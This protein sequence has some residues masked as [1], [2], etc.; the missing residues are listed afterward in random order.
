M[1]I[2]FY[3]L[4]S[5]RYAPMDKPQDERA[6]SVKLAPNATSYRINGLIRSKPYMIHLYTVNNGVHSDPANLQNL[7]EG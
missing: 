3:L 6:D 4:H 5:F 7:P 1:K 2:V